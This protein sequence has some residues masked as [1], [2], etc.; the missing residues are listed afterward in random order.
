MDEG[1]TTFAEDNIM[2]ATIDSN[3]HK[4][5][6]EDSYRNYFALV[7]NGREEPMSQHADHFNTNNG[8]SISSY[9]KGA[10]FWNSWGM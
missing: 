8:Y 3:A 1:F 2:Q 4:W 10:V 9:S 5:A 6:L 7:A